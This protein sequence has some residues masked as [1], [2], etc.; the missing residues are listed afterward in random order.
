MPLG[1]ARDAVIAVQA[2]VIEALAAENARLAGQVADLAARVERLERL[3]SRNSGNSSMPPS[4]DDLPGRT[5]PQGK[6]AGG[7]KRK[8]GKQPGAPGS[9]L[10]WS[11][12]P[13]GTLPHFP[14]GTC[15]CGAALAGAADLGV[16]A[17]HQQ[18]EIPLACAQVIQHDLHAVACACGRVHQAA[19]PAGA[20][21]AGTVTYGLNLQAWCVFLMAAHAIPVHRCGELI[22]ALTGARPSPGFVHAMIARAAAAVA[23]ANRLIRALIILAHVICADETPIRAGPGPKTRKR[24]LLVAC[25]RLLTY[26]FLGDRSLATFGAF[27]FPDLAGVVV[28]HDR[29]QNYDAFPGIIHQLCAAHLLRDLAD[30]AETY[31]VAIWPGQIADALRGLI[32][33]ANRARDKGLGAVP[34]DIAAPLIHTFRHGVL[35]GLSEIP[36]RPGRKQHPGR[37]L[38]ECLRDRRDDVLRFAFDLR[39][40]PTSNDAERDLR[41]AKTQ[42][43]ISGRL[44]SGETTRQRYAIRGYL[45]TAAKHGIN[46]LTALRDALAGHPWMPPIPDPP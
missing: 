26:Y 6:Q 31:P 46:V 40:P 34:D 23:Q 43:K 10:A 19:A 24:Y 17:S 33:A 29:Y 39:I 38:L 30:A 44:R 37:N 22:E 18:V 9:H 7:G 25:T 13:D 20:G 16:V 35:A 15:E 12:H 14:E 41:P 32:H 4:A 27:V 28:V 2:R 1:A 5:P 3:A 36:R 11:E 21:T 45:S 8:P 42:Q